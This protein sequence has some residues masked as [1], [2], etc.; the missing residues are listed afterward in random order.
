MSMLPSVFISYSRADSVFVDQLEAELSK[1]GFVTWLDRQHLEA[2]DD[3]A[4]V[5]QAQISRHNLVVVVLS[6]D[7]VTSEWI[8]REIAFAQQIRKEIIPVL[9]KTTQVP[10]RISELQFVDFTHDFENGAIQLRTALSKPRT[11]TPSPQKQ[12]PPY[13]PPAT[14]QRDI[15]VDVPAPP[16]EPPPDL[17]VLYMQAR[18][19]FA[20]ADWD[21]AEALLQQVVAR[22]PKYDRGAAQADV[23][24]SRKNLLPVQINRLKT[25]AD[26]AHHAGQWGEE[27]A[28]WRAVLGI[29]AS[30][31]EAKQR[32]AIAE[33]NQQ[34]ERIYKRAGAFAKA[35]DLVAARGEIERLKTEA[36]F[37]GDPEQLGQQLGATLA[38]NYILYQ[39]QSQQQQRQQIE[40]Q[41][42]VRRHQEQARQERLQ[43]ID[44][45]ISEIEKKISK[46]EHQ[47]FRL[48]AT[49]NGD[50]SALRLGC[51][52]RA[53]VAFDFLIFLVAIFYLILWIF[54]IQIEP[55][56]AW[57]GVDRVSAAQH[58]FAL[59]FVTLIMLGCIAY[60]ANSNVWGNKERIEDFRDKQRDIRTKSLRARLEDLRRQRRAIERTDP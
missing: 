27:I 41:K 60:Y 58:F 40:H 9:A 23:A 50:T 34:A 56:W 49:F 33:Q 45:E 59:F 16:L 54:N 52:H 12:P 13:T 11:G 43:P 20:R 42:Q 47:K 25:K 8:N 6:P 4:A 53:L 57:N 1:H 3:W 26:A 18:S 30:H 22:D 29:D 35:K 2:G 38:P 44:T 46:I 36:P 5:I 31:Q 10:F 19:A 28:C 39:Q 7:A 37:Y 48:Y 55:T 21:T 17:E 51:L 15:L 32:L 24:I 14:V